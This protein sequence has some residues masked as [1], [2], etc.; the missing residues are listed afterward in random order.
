MNGA[1]DLP[2]RVRAG[3]LLAPGRRVV[4]L[5]SGGRDSVCLLDL[6]VLIAGREAVR[7]LHVDHGLRE[8]AAADTAAVAALCERLGVPLEVHR[9]SPPTGPGNLQA[10][11]RE[12]RYRV[13]TRLAEA[14]DADLAAGHTVTDQAETILQRLVSSPGRRA[15]L[16]MPDERVPVVRPLLR[17]R[18]TREQTAAWCAAR[19][20]PWREDPTNETDRFARGRIRARALPALREVH[21]GAEENIVRTAELLADEAEVLEGLVET[22]L[23]GRDHVALGDL[24]ALPPA[25][26]RLVVRRLAEEATG[27]L[28]PRAARRLPELLALGAERDG[29]RAALDVGGGARAVVGDGLLWFERTPRLRSRA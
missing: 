3:R 22:V 2:E 6:A 15:L 24:G 27:A 16:G 18:A 14:H 21:P 23:D 13:G 25:V 7:A 17:A 9:A 4:V 20:L 28:C 5:V 29:R 10:W 12:L 8:E 1:P 11:G 19:G 26:A